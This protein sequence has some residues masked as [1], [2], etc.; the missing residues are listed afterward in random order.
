MTREEWAR[1]LPDPI[2][3][4]QVVER[5]TA[6]LDDVGAAATEILTTRAVDTPLSLA[7]AQRDA[8]KLRDGA[9]QYAQHAP[10]TAWALS[11]DVGKQGL[12]VGLALFDGLDDLR[13]VAMGAP[14]PDPLINPIEEAKR[15]GRGFERMATG[16]KEAAQAI[17]TLAIIAGLLYLAHKFGEDDA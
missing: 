8:Q 3:P 10:E 11:S 16:A 12:A 1:S 4:A 7:N 2:Q 5:L 17:P 13:R 15:V 9:A 14:A 6:A